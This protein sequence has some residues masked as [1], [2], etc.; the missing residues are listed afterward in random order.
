MAQ[1]RRQGQKRRA[2]V[3]KALT[4]AVRG[5]IDKIA[6]AL[7]SDDSL[8]AMDLLT[9]QHRYVEKLF[10]HIAKEEGA[11]KSVA[12]RELADILAIH[13]AV[14]ERIFYPAVKSAST[15]D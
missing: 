5:G 10:A 15:D 4:D 8:N 6:T 7:A 2:G 1:R 14:E 9:A 3:M 13:A 11:R 12:F